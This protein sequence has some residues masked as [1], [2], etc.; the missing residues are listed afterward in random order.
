MRKLGSKSF[1]GKDGIY[2]FWSWRK[3]SVIIF[4]VF[5]E[6]KEWEGGGC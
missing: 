2:V 3:V 6:K 5:E 4:F 1:W